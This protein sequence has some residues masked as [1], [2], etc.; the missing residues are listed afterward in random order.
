MR[1]V[2]ALGGNA[3]LRRGE[4]LEA[5]AQQENLRRA[6]TS[7][8]EVIQ[9]NQVVITTLALRRSST[10]VLVAE[11]RLALNSSRCLP[12]RTARHRRR[13]RTNLSVKEALAW[14]L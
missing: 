14:L 2:V 1:I 9:D 12:R 8:A 13:V 11:R 3:L 5:D 4:P 10:C 7:L 6:V